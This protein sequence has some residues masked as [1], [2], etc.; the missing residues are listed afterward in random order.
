[1]KTV[2]K[3]ECKDRVG[4]RFSCFSVSRQRSVG[5]DHR[6]S[7]HDDRSLRVAYVLRSP[8]KRG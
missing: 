7:L 5:S 4:C 8:S 6:T 2:C 3:Q 1:M